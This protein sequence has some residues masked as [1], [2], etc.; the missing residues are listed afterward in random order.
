MTE[1]R[2]SVRLDFG[3]DGLEL[4]VPAGV[5]V[6]RPRSVE[7]LGERAAVDALRAAFRAPSSGAPLA[8]LVRPGA[9]VAVSIC[10]VTRPFPARVVLP[11]LLEELP[12]RRVRLCVATGSHRPCT[13][14]ELDAMF[15]ADVL[16]AVELLQHDA[17]DGGAH[18]ALGTVPGSDVPAL[19]DRAF[20]DADARVTLGF[21]EPH[22]FAGF[23]GGP[24]MVAPGLA[25]L[26]TIRE[27]HSATRIGDAR[28]TWGIVEGN[29]VHD[30]IRG[31]AARAGVTFALD[32]A[33]GSDKGIGAVFAGDL[34]T[35]HAAAMAH[36]R[37]SAMVP[38]E[39]PY[40]VVVTTNSGYPLDQNLYQ[41]VKGLKAAAGITRDG[42]TIILAAACEDGLPSHGSYAALLGR[43]GS[44]G[45]FLSALATGAIRERDQWQVQ[46]QAE[47][48]SR[49]RVLA[50]TPG[51]A[52]DDLRRAWMS[53]VADVGTALAEA[54]A[55]AG[56]GARAAILPEGPQTIAYV[57]GAQGRGSPGRR[58]SG[59]GSVDER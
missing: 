47:I 42:G 53:P 51:V 27:L 59:V 49:V 33:L 16:A 43:S 23:S 10:D 22:F 48:C 45:E 35:E 28:A 36:V 39:A 25:A 13:P 2:T 24:K 9:V 52:G 54:L 15:G 6:L 1:T 7:A 26:E 32:V 17:D 38:V 14:A 3:R 44:P 4:P 46:V 11:V 37:S 40:D 29:P 18:G 31:I 12:G 20:L 5:D 56:P 19:V 55:A 41:C 57:V 30:P 50:H 58:A 8:S 21:V 34:G